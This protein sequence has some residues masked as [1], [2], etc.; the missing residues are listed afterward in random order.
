MGM[1]EERKMNRKTRSQPDLKLTTF[2]KV[3]EQKH[4]ELK[5]DEFLNSTAYFYETQLNL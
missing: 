2:T 1:R 5:A 3:R 4:S